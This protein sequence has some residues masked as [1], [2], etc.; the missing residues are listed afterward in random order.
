MKIAEEIRKKGLKKYYGRKKAIFWEERDYLKTTVKAGVIILPTIGCR[1]GRSVGCTMC[2]YVYDSPRSITQ[3]TIVEEFRR[4]MRDLSEVEYLKIFTSG[5]FLDEQEI[6][7]KTRDNIIA[8][9]NEH[10]I[11]RV[12]VESRPEFVSEGVLKEIKEN[13]IAELEIGIGLETT[14]DFIRERFINKGFSLEDFKSSLEECKKC[15]V[16]VK[17]YLLVKPPFMNEKNSIEDAIKS[18]IEVYELGVD[19]ISYNPVNIQRATVVEELWRRGEYRAPWL[20]SVVYIL[21]EVKRRVNIP[22]LSH[23]IAAGKERGPHNCGKCDFRVYK[24]I[25]DFS[26][27]QNLENLEELECECKDEWIDTVELE[28][29]NH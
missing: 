16:K 12:Q 7:N 2:G 18:G 14:S 19:R 5:S 11:K 6:T 4:A 21:N 9:L 22:V 27:T 10:E 26:V 13:L 17:T 28:G 8:I 23:P 24:S 1:W 25:I 29:F 15:G 20:W 3:D